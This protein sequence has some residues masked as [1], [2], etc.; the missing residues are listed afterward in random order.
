[1]LSLNHEQQEPKVRTTPLSQMR[2]L[3]HSMTERSQLFSFK[4]VMNC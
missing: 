1:M 4:T 3:R 2:K